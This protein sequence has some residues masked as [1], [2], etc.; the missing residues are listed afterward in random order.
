MY[1][2]ICPVCRRMIEI[3]A[4]AAVVGARSKCSKCWS[5]LVTSNTHPL[6]V[7]QSS[8]IPHETRSD[9]AEKVGA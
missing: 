8:S 1:E 3:P 6:R 5:E 9:S 7:Q 2:I 4:H